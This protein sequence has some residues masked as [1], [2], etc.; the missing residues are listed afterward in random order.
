M[1]AKLTRM[2]GRIACALVAVLVVVGCKDKKGGAPVDKAAVAE[3]AA[4]TDELKKE[5]DMVLTRRNELQRERKTVSDSRAAL[6]E[7]RTQ[8]AAA[9]GNLDAVDKEIA[10]LEA[11]EKALADEDT[12]LEQ[13][14]DAV[15]RRSVAL[16]GADG[17]TS[18]R[19]A[20]MAL[21]EKD[22]ARREERIAERESTIAMR[23]RDLAKREKETCGVGA[24]TTIVR[25]VEAPKG[26][27][28]T[29]RDVEPVLKRARR[30]MAEK[31][32]LNSDL[33]AQAASLEKDAT[34]AMAEG[35]YGKAK[36][37]ADQLM[38]TVDGMKVDKAFVSA[39]FAR[40][41]AAM[42]G[43]QLTADQQE[44]LKGATGDIG[45][46]K[47]GAANAK[48]NKLYASLR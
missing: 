5:E 44:L 20:G 24:T 39:K 6:T 17:D 25:E 8:V 30:K 10:E 19:E 40:L 35:D 32:I 41:S 1:R 38:D 27:R 13:K 21:R 3:L 7:K 23:E 14:Y 42:K 28:Y 43:K 15:V 9:G 2:L 33:P 47:Y 36:G 18:K 26:S 22:V 48:L 29:K 31:G 11:K 16:A 4:K 45:D 46:G 34:A 12:A 37:D